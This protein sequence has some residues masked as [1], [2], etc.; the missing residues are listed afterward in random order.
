M[1]LSIYTIVRNG[2]FFDTHVEAMLRHHLPLADEII[3]NDG[4]S[5]DGTYE[6]ITRIDSKVKVFREEWEVGTEPG[7]LYAK[8]K[9]HARV[10]CTGDWCIMMDCDEF[11]PEWDFERVRDAL[12]RANGPIGQLRYLQFYG[13]YKVENIR[14]ERMKWFTWKNNIHRNQ[15]DMQVVYDGAN[16]VLLGSPTPDGGLDPALHFLCHH[17]GQVISPARL[18]QKWRIQERLKQQTPKWDRVPAVAFDIAPFN[19]FD[20]DIVND[21]AVYEGPYVKAVRDDP[22]EFVRDEMRLYEYLT[23]KQPQQT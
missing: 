7:A 11:I 20:Q 9:N 18:R 17:M 23:G 19:W 3:V 6:R 4:L 2:L 1:K 13:N 8:A 5:T 16:V 10:R 22:T 12:G 21:L 14:P 15:S